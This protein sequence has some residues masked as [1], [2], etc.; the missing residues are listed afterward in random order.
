MD[1]V[2]NYQLWP[3]D[4][5]KQKM[6]REVIINDYKEI[7]MIIYKK[8]ILQYFYE[9]DIIY[10]I[11]HNLKELCTTFQSLESFTLR[12]SLEGQNNFISCSGNEPYIHKIFDLKWAID[13][14][15]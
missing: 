12:I 13:I 15:P 10:T 3:K 7:S 9:N 8:K 14:I 1:N 6:G 2:Q 11:I 4:N 5:L